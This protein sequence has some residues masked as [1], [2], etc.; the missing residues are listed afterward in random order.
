[1]KEKRLITILTG[2]C[3]FFSLTALTLDQGIAFAASDK[4]ITLKFAH[5]NP[6]KGRT[7]V[8]LIDAY[9]NKVREVTKGR[10]EI[11]VYPAQSLIKAKEMV[12]GIETGVADMAWTPLGYF[13][14][15]FPLTT[16]TMLPFMALDTGG[17]NSLVLQE[18]FE[19]IP[20]VKREYRSVKMLSLHASDAYH[21]FT[22][23]RPVRTLEDIKGLKLRIMG[24][25]PIMASKRLGLSPL[26]MPMPGVYEAG[27]KG[28]LDGAA[29]PWA[30]VATFNLFEVYPY[31]TNVDLWSAPFMIFMNKDKWDS[32]PKDIQEAIESVSNMNAARWLGDAAWG[33]V[34]KDET[35][36]KAEKAGKKLEMI[37]LAPG[38]LEKWKAIAGPPVWDSWVEEMNKKGLPG[39]KVLD[40]AEKLMK[41]Y[42]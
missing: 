5:Q 35:L 15:R 31:W 7:T 37:S 33:P 34:V 20:E 6:P 1:M 42:Q 13:T 25:Y 21:V 38:E 41:K 24:A 29:L 23:K 10:L 40:A 14:G 26:F 28:V 18:L 9:I 32:L 12:T 39:K 3:F 16:V 19:T 36:A 17:K 8:K 2:L 11:V 4:P 22:S 30:A 27:E